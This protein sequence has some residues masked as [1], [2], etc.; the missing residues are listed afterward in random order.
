MTSITLTNTDA[1]ILTDL[2]AALRDATLD[3][4][5]VFAQVVV[6]AG[7]LDTRLAGPSP[8]AMVRY[9]STSE[10][11]APEG[12]RACVVTAE[13]IVL[14]RLQAGAADGDRISTVLGLLSAA[15]NAVEAGPPAAACHAYSD[16]G[17]TPRL[18]WGE[19]RLDD[20]D[21][22][23]GRGRIEVTVAYMIDTPTNH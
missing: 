3:G 16:A 1:T 9:R 6:S 14:T 8:K 4:S 17:L 23:W 19:P 18:Q 15:R 22:P 11:P 7:A 20:P 12:R 2:A 21:G 10:R 5:A 13:L